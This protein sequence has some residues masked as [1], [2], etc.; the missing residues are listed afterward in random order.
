MRR[1]HSRLLAGSMAFGALCTVAQGEPYTATEKATSIDLAAGADRH[2]A[3]DPATEDLRSFLARPFNMD[4]RGLS[5]ESLPAD[6]GTIPP[7]TPS[8]LDPTRSPTSL[9]AYDP[10]TVAALGVPVGSAVAPSVDLT[11]APSAEELEGRRVPLPVKPTDLRIPEPAS[12][13]L[14][15]TGLIGLTA[16]RHLHRNRG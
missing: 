4:G 12:I 16:R 1:Q 10:G 2:A 11:A 5:P 7:S 3:A 14:L 15:L 8:G 9:N 13:I 6:P